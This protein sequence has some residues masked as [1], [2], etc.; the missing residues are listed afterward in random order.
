MPSRVWLI[1]LQIDGGC[2]VNSCL[3]EYLLCELQ[4]IHNSIQEGDRR[5]YAQGVALVVFALQ[6]LWRHCI[7][8]PLQIVSNI[9][10]AFEEAL[11]TKRNVRRLPGTKRKAFFVIG[12][13]QPHLSRHASNIRCTCI[14][15]LWDDSACFAVQLPKVVHVGQCALQQVSELFSLQMSFSSNAIQFPTVHVRLKFV[16]GGTAACI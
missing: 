8:S 11:V 16:W 7:E 9:Q 14:A 10:Q 3:V 2:I 5:L 1:A 15:N 13:D 6:C 4:A 12:A